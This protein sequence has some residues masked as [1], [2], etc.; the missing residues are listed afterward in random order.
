MLQRLFR[1]ATF[2]ALLAALSGCDTGAEALLNDYA[3]RVSR[4]LDAE[5]PPLRAMDLPAYPR[6]RD[7]IQTPPDIRLDLLDAWALR[8]CEVFVLIGERNSI[9]GRVADPI[10]RLDYERRLL[11][12]L[13]VCLN[14]DIELDDELRASLE[15]ALSQKRATFNERLWNATLANPDYSGYWTDGNTPIQPDDDIDANGYAANQRALADLVANPMQSTQDDWIRVIQRT[16]EYSMGGHSLQSM[17]LA[18]AYLEQTEAMLRAAAEDKRLCPMGPAM[19]ELGY[20]RNVMA[21]VFVGQVQPWLGEVDRRFLAGFESL[22]TMTAELG[23][24]SEALIRYSEAIAEVHGH[25][26]AAIRAQVDSWE[27]LISKCG[28]EITR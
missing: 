25:F 19:K 7:L 24:L 26:R 14:S 21:N 28:V 12:L 23:A 22:N 5:R 11:E 20:A 6:P 17:R 3:T 16:T 13:P 4:V 18:I 27:S 2:F 10:I 8:G 15:D 9:L 1:F